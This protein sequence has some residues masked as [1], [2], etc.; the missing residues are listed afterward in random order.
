MCK[1][2]FAPLTTCVNM[3]VCMFSWVNVH[4]C[5]M[6][7]QQDELL[8]MSD[9]HASIQS[10]ADGTLLQTV[11]DAAAPP[12]AAAKTP[13]AG[14]AQH[15]TLSVPHHKQHNR[16]SSDAR[17]LTMHA[18]LGACNQSL[19]THTHARP[20]THVTCTRTYTTDTPPVTIHLMEH[21]WSLHTCL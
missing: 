17:M 9:V 13:A 8:M 16:N 21:H 10:L 1:T 5:R 14:I 18:L 11:I 2:A 6:A 20:S 4:V 3:C 12:T 19:F 7:V 15:E